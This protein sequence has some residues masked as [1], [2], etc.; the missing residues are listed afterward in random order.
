MDKAIPKERLRSCGL[1]ATPRRLAI[2][3]YLESCG[4]ARTAEDVHSRLRPRLGRLGL[5]TVYRVL[6]ELADAGLL[7]RVDRPDKVRSYAACR[8]EGKR[9]HHHIVCTG[10][11]RVEVVECEFPA[12]QRRRI[13]RSTGFRVSDHQ[14]QVEGLCPDCRRE[15]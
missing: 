12:E 6:E 4:C 3:G 10:C 9:H 11:G 1:K 2:A 5:Q 13:E 15:R 14:M 7:A 8:A